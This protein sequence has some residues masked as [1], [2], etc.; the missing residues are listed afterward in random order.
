MRIAVISASGRQPDWVRS[1]FETYA[2]RLQG[3]CTLELR[4][5]ALE[6]RTRSAVPSKLVEKESRRMLAAIPGG[7]H[8]VALDETGS[9]WSTVE[10]ARRLERWL[11]RGAPVALLV[12]GPDGLPPACL[13]RADERWSLSALT[14]PH[15]LV[16]V[17]VAEAVYRADSL[18]RGHPYHRD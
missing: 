6:K 18:R 15:G 7:A 17:I 4:E 2:R 14:L 5:V 8:V 16:R 3:A 12:G 10:L 9:A 11:E 1:G 13:E